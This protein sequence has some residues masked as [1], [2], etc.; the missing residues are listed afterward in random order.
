MMSTK[1]RQLRKF[2]VDAKGNIK[3]KFEE[4]VIIAPENKEEDSREVVIKYS[5]EGEHKPHEDLTASFTKLRK[6]ALEIG[7]FPDDTKT[8]NQ[9]NMVS[10]DIAG[11]KDLQNSRVVFTMGKFIKGT[12]NKNIKVGPLPQVV[13]YGE[14]YPKA[15][16]MTKQIEA[17]IAEIWLYMDG[18]NADKV[19]LAFSFEKQ[20]A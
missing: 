11:D 12:K 20:A 6:F 19:Q 8:R 1:T 2:K 5:V 18:K 14:E 10:M 16:E 17:V 3:I 9:Y 7:E 13:M 15:D 4:R